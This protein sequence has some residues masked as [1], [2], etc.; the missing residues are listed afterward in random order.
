MAELVRLHAVRLVADA[1]VVLEAEEE[2]MKWHGG[3][4][5]WTE[6]GTA[7]ISVVFSWQRQKAYQLAVWYKTQGFTVNIGG[8]SVSYDPDMFH[9]VANT[10][11]SVGNVLHRHNSKATFTS[12]G[13]VRKCNFCIVPKSEGYLVELEEWEIKPIVCD[14]NIL[15]TSRKH[16]DSVVDKLKPLR[17]I[18]FNQGL[19]ARLM[20]KHH[21]ERLSELN[22]RMVRL[23]WDHVG[24]ENEFMKAWNMLRDV[25]FKK[26]HI[27]PYV[28]IGFKDTPEDALYRLQTVKDLGAWPFPMR[29]QPLDVE[30]RNSYVAPN[31]TERELRDYM[32]YWSRQRWLE[33][34]PFEE[35]C[36]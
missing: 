27:R 12:R 23:A 28:L 26:T 3:L 2:D 15:A 31:W 30:K 16:F 34:V 9:A 4:V 35:Y 24:M 19:D 36:A 21:A 25:G 33:H 20:T 32:R 5:H 17:G 8:P 18:D 29:Y 11:V 10:D 13:C 7:N 6:N 1:V 22:T 14:N